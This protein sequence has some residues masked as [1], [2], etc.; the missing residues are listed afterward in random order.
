MLIVIYNTDPS[1][2]KFLLIL[3]ASMA[4]ENAPRASPGNEL[5][6]EL[7]PM[8]APHLEYV[9]RLVA[10]MDPNNRYQIESIQG[11]GISRAVMHIKTGVVR[12]PKINGIVVENSGA[13]W[14]ERIHSKKAC[15]TYPTF[16]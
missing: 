3:Y 1:F 9:Y 16:L 13:D 7:P 11:T 10:D 4:S 15:F 14:A 5:F 2:V 6:P 12:G 8:R